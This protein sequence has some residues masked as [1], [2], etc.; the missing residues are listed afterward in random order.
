MVSP[1]LR[2]PPQLPPG[3]FPFPLL[4]NFAQI[5]LANPHRTMV[6]W[7]FRYGPLF[8]VHLPKP[9]IVIADF[10]LLKETLISQGDVF[11]GRPDSF[12]YGIFTNHRKEGDGIILAEG[13][14][15]QAQR[16]FALRAFRNLG[17]GTKKM[18]ET[19]MYHVNE[20]LVRI[21]K[22]I[23]YSES[24]IIDL[25]YPLA[26]CIGNIIQEM[27]MG[28][29]YCYNDP[30]F[31]YFKHLIDN[32]LKGVASVQM[33][34]VD[35]YPWMRHIL[36]GYKSYVNDG[37]ALQKFFL[38]EIE[39]HEKDLDMNADSDNF[40]DAYL[41]DMKN[42]E[43]ELSKLTLALNAG[44]LWTGGMETTVTTL[45]WMIAY[46]IHYPGIQRELFEEIRS[47]IG[48]RRVTTADRIKMPK[49]RAA[50]D[51]IQRIVN[52]LPW[53]IPHTVRETVVVRGYTIPVGTTIMPQPGAVAHNPL[54]FSQPE[55]FRIGRFLDEE[56]SY[57]QREEFTPF[58][59]GKR[60]CLGE[61]LAR[62]ELFLILVSL[63]QH[64][65]FGPKEGEAELPSLKK[66][67]GM[68][69]VPNEFECY[70]RR[71]S[72][73]EE[74]PPKLDERFEAMLKSMME[75]KL[76]ESMKRQHQKTKSNLESSESSEDSGKGGF[77]LAEMDTD[78]EGPNDPFADF[79]V[80]EATLLKRDSLDLALD[81]SEILINESRKRRKSD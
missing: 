67:P 75:E 73:K 35:E 20:L 15:W 11:A 30:E 56:G 3:P 33:L 60:Q 79:D 18:D 81:A 19:I 66:S 80:N 43:K 2:D 6:K 36:P 1:P 22:E 46:L 16:R 32:T 23:Y 61:G 78:S 50:I 53:H 29:T 71:R 12:L 8:T 72:A 58:G 51:E 49:I 44:D 63:L 45:R 34:L 48:P 70:V 38:D 39:R 64:F 40:I 57:K 68:A 31:L 69:S 27:V 9:I 28:R 65:E 7:A 52:V 17:M 4:G 25:H 24:T 21:Q 37:F 10:Q 76:R 5:D 77:R 55:H 14:R 42:G 74:E 41:K 26:F 47:V 54:L 13:E 59:L 62:A